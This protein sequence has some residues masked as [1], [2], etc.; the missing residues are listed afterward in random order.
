MRRGQPDKSIDLLREN[1]HALRKYSQSTVRAQRCYS[2]L[3]D[4]DAALKA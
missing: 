1:L 3:D 4:A 2:A